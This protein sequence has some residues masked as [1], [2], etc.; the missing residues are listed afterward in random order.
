MPGY[1]TPQPGSADRRP[2]LDQQW[3][4]LAVPWDVEQGYNLRQ[5]S[6]TR[7]ELRQSDFAYDP[8]TDTFRDT[9]TG[10]VFFA[11]GS[12]GLYTTDTFDPDSTNRRNEGQF[13]T[14]G[15]R[16]GWAW[17]TTRRSSPIRVCGPTSCRS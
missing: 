13:L 3:R 16:S 8:E 15:G 4:D 5:S 1:D 2:Q 6:P 12:V 11:N 9:A 14:R 7:G 10:A 17:T